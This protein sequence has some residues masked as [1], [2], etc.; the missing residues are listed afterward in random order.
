MPL[1]LIVLGSWVL[2]SSLLEVVMY[3]RLSCVLAFS[4]ELLTIQGVLLYR[5]VVIVY[6]GDCNGGLM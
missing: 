2:R 3:F 1:L 6:F 5:S 4:I